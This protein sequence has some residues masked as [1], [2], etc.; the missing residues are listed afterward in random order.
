MQL[1]SARIVALMD[2]LFAIDR[3]AREQSLDYAQRDVLPSSGG[4][5]HPNCWSSCAA[6]RWR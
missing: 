2:E 5:G 3:E 4:S 1:K 6:P